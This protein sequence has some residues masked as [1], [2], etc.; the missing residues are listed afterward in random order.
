VVYTATNIPHLVADIVIPDS[1][2]D[3]VAL[4]VVLCLIGLLINGE[5]WRW[6]R[7]QTGQE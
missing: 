5:G 7:Q 6:W 2:G 1:R 4:M 3:Q